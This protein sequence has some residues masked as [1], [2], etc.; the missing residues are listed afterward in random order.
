VEE[1]MEPNQQNRFNNRNTVIADINGGGMFFAALK[2]VE[3]ACPRPVEDGSD[4]GTG[5][6]SGPFL[7]KVKKQPITLDQEFLEVISQNFLYVGDG[8]SFYE[9][10]P[11]GTYATIKENHLS[12]KLKQQFQLSSSSPDP[13]ILSPTQQGVMYIHDNRRCDKAIQSAEGYGGNRVLNSGGI[14]KVDDLPYCCYL[15][16]PL[17]LR[18]RFAHPI[19]LYHQLPW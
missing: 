4:R 5:E 19:E 9:R 7:V 1:V 18:I 11:N 2:Q 12:S 10:L 13:T 14:I 6:L 8:N 3:E 17:I 16:T 15:L